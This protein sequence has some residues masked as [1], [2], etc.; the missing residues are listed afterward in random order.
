[1]R[2]GDLPWIGTE[3]VEVMACV[4]IVQHTITSYKALVVVKFFGCRGMGGQSALGP[5]M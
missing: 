3:L 5:N 2:A 4:K 1:M